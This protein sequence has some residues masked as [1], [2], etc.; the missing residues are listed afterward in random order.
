[1]EIEFGI[2]LRI[3]NSRIVNNSRKWSDLELVTVVFNLFHH[4]SVM[5]QVDFKLFR[6]RQNHFQKYDY[7]FGFL[8]ALTTWAVTRFEPGPGARHS[9]SHRGCRPVLDPRLIF[10][11]T[12]SLIEVRSL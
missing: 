12:K 2:I 7:A 8:F 6:H 9:S 1:M 3:R 4:Q 11:V 10:G 5:E